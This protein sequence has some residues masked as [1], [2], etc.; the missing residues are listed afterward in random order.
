MAKQIEQ[1][2]NKELHAECKK[3]GTA[4]LEA[5]RKFA[6]LLP[7]VNR[8]EIQARAEGKSWLVRKGY[9]GIFEFAARLAGMSRDESGSGE[10]SVASK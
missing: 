1:L 10:P 3:F 6:G 7:E 2:T 8:R 5:K 9:S 4:A